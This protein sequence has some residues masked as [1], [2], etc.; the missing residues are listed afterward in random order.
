VPLEIL[1]GE[2]QQ[3]SRDVVAHQ[4]ERLAVGAA[5]ALEDIDPGSL[6]DAGLKRQ[7]VG[8]RL[9][10]EAQHARV[11]IPAGLGQ[12]VVEA[13]QLDLAAHLGVHDLRAHTTLADQ[14]PALDQV[15]DGPAHGRPGQ[16]ELVGQIDLVVQPCPGG[17]FPRLDEV[18]QVLRHLE[19]ERD[20][21][22]A[23][24][25]GQDGTVHGYLSHGH[26]GM[27]PLWPH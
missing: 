19:V 11:R 8:R 13:G 18:L 4:R 2:V 26:V 14:Q 22:V 1:R 3:A 25:L 17:Q 16:A 7:G 27:H 15:L 10:R 24:H 9:L 6:G 12:V 23:V 20:R 5:Q 21:A